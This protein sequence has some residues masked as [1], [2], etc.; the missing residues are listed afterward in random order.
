MSPFWLW[1]W[2]IT[3]SG[4]VADL[5]FNRSPSHSAVEVR[6]SARRREPPG[7]VAGVGNVFIPS[8]R[9]AVGLFAPVQR[10]LP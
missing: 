1:L 5:A 7:V 2:L 6:A 3:L 4:L 8:Q 9:P 10:E